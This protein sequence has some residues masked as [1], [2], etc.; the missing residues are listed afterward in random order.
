MLNLM[1]TNL[2]QSHQKK[3]DDWVKASLK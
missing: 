1:A 2:Q 3:L